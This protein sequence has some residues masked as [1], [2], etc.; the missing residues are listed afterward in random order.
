MA[1]CANNMRLGSFCALDSHAGLSCAGWTE[2]T[3]EDK[4]VQGIDGGIQNKKLRVADIDHEFQKIDCGL[5]KIMKG[6]MNNL[7]CGRSIFC[8]VGEVNVGQIA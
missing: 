4:D 7:L 2:V 6:C 1:F 5:Q 8:V 3:G